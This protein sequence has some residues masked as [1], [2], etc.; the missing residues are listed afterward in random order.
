MMSI[1]VNQQPSFLVETGMLYKAFT[2]KFVNDVDLSSP[3]Y[4]QFI[5]IR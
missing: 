5:K 2:A 4:L 1:M 3:E